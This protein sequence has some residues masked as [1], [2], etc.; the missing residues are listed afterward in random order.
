MQ[1]PPNPRAPR[2]GEVRNDRKSFA[3]TIRNGTC[4]DSACGLEQLQFGGRSS[5]LVCVTND[6]AFTGEKVAGN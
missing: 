1:N 5:G 3:I 6:G 2:C 4:A